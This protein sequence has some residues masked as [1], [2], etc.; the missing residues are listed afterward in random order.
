M[1]QHQEQR[2]KQAMDKYLVED[3]IEDICRQLSCS[4]S[5]L[6]KWRERYDAQ[7]PTWTQ[8]RSTRPKSHPTQTPE[9]VEQAIVSLHL[10]LRHNGTGGGVTAIAQ[11][12]I[13][14]G[15]APVPAR[16]TIDRILR[17]HYKRGK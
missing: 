16:R 7:N 11:A 12:L 15:I 1:S 13:Q 17:R 10:S 5:W 8:E 9:S 4:K 14:Q 6:Y 3:K 2:R